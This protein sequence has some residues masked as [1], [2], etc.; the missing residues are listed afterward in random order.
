MDRTTIGT[1]AQKFIEE[2][3]K[4]MP[5]SVQL[6]EITPQEKAMAATICT[7]FALSL[8]QWKDV[9][10]DGLPEVSGLYPVIEKEDGTKSYAYY[11]SRKEIW[12]TEDGADVVNVVAYIPYPIPPYEKKEEA[13]G[14]PS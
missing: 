5:L 4:K 7:D 8:L 3:A 14:S 13:D 11:I 1:A 9:A 10:L 12:V 2:Q 6:Y